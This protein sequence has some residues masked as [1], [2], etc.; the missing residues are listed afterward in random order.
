MLSRLKF[1]RAQLYSQGAVQCILYYLQ[2]P[3]LA[4]QGLI[5]AAHSKNNTMQTNG[6]PRWKVWTST[7]EINGV[8]MAEH[9]LPTVRQIH[10]ELLHLAFI[11]AAL[12]ILNAPGLH[13]SCPG[14]HSSCTGPAF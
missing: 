3:I 10:H 13:S 2:A 9:M 7:A 11:P 12:C 14:L 5:P 6:F 4:A 1:K 8:T